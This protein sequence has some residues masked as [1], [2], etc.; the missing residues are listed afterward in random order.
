VTARDLR[1][2]GIWNWK[3]I[4]TSAEVKNLF[5]AFHEAQQEMQAVHKDATNPFF[6]SSYATLENVVSVVKSAFNGKGLSFTQA[7]GALVE[8]ELTVSTRIMHVS[9]EWMESD[10]QMP[11]AKKDPQGTGAALSYSCRYSLMAIC[12]LPATDDDA[13][14]ATDRDNKPPINTN[15]L[16]SARH[17]AMEGNKA[18]DVYLKGLS[19]DKQDFLKPHATSL[20]QAANKA[21]EGLMA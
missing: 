1:L 5:K 8:G 6:K 19:K 10:F 13:E 14:S 15:L 17:V 16:D 11:L 4:Q 12:G 7:P 21:D 2:E 20:R 9:G 18:L 3:M